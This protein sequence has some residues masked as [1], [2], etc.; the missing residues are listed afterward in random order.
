MDYCA[1]PF[2][3]REV[4]GDKRPRWRARPQRGWRPRGTIVDEKGGGKK[5][6]A[7]RDLQVSKAGLGESS[8]E[9]IV[10]GVRR[11]RRKKTTRI[12][13]SSASQLE[14]AA[15]VDAEEADR[16]DGTAAR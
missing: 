9:R 6:G 13:R 11:P 14:M 4:A 1:W 7:H 3:H 10:D 8:P 5:A 2:G 15:V 16:V 12:R